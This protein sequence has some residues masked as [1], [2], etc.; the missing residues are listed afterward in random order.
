MDK[1]EQREIIAQI[2]GKISDYDG[3]K[4]DGFIAGLMWT[5][6]LIQ[7]GKDYADQRITFHTPEERIPDD[8]EKRGCC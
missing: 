2:N 8:F 4:E 7:H 1:T 3:P 6:Y 5:M